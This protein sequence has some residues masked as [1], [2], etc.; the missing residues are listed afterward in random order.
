[1]TTSEPDEL[2]SDSRAF[3]LNR[4]GRAADTDFTPTEQ[5]YR[6]CPVTELDPADPERLFPNLISFYPDWSVNRQKF[7]EP[8][9]VLYPDY[10]GWGVAAFQVK[11]IPSPMKTEGN[12][13][14]H[15]DVQHQPSE[16]N[17]SH[18]EI[19]TYKHGTHLANPKAETDPKPPD[20]P[21]TIKKYFRTVL[22]ERARIICAP[23]TRPGPQ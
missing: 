9:D 2:E 22:S 20:L 15:W 1:M 19:W 14:Y 12:V 17:Y 21:K 8:E 11:D 7:S 10:L 23:K 13:A 3:R 4:R 5:L 18:T 6:R 16:E